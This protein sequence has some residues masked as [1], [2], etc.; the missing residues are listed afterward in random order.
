MTFDRVLELMQW[1]NPF[2]DPPGDSKARRFRRV[3]WP[4]DA[5]KTWRIWHVDDVGDQSTFE[6]GLVQGWGWQ[7]GA[8]DSETVPVNGIN[9]RDGTMYRATYDDRRADDWEVI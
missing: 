3:C 4:K 9:Q 6:G 5:Q 8:E 7:L 1:Q 2:G